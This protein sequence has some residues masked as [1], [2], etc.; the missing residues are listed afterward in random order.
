MLS[1]FAGKGGVGGSKA[2]GNGFLLRRKKLVDRKQNG[3]GFLEWVD[4]KQMV[5]S[6]LC[7]GMF[8]VAKEISSFALLIPCISCFL[9]VS[10]PQGQ[11]Y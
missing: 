8:S 1:C 11:T 6:L 7:S 2:N 9:L 3:N 5:I 10:E 4:R